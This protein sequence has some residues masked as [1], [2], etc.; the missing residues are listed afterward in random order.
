MSRLTWITE[1]E[2]EREINDKEDKISL[3]TSMNNFSSGVKMRIVSGQGS[4]VQRP[5][6]ANLSLNFNAGFFFFYSKAFS[7]V[8]FSVHLTSSN[9]HNVDKT[10]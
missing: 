6:S 3:E 8:M 4:V 2:L 7:R 5:I 1:K 9:H 10:N